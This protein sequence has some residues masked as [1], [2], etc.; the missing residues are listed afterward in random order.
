MLTLTTTASA[1]T[2]TATYKLRATAIGQSADFTLDQGLDSTAPATVA[3]GAVFSVVIDPAPNA[4]PAKVKDYTVREIKKLVLKLTV[5]ANAKFQSA[6]VSGGAGLGSTPTVAV[7]GNNVV[8]K[9][10]GP[11]KGGSAFE[12]PTITV[13]LQAGGTGDIVTKLTGTSYTDPG[14]TF[15]AAITAFGFPIDAPATG[16][17][18]PNPPLTTT[19]IG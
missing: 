16:Y 1:A 6:K 11:I 10:A 19:T 18:D 12:L 15:T 13:T 5:P 4:V 3:P 9:I 7:E 17:P 2:Q 8:L 14:L